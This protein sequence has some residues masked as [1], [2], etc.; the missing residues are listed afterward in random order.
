[1]MSDD[2]RFTSK[3]IFIDEGAFRVSGKINT[4]NCRNWALQ[5]PR[6][7]VEL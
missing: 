4:P 6:A 7:S 2:D 1:V 5:N 3:V